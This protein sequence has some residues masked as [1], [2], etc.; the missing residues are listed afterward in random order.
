MKSIVVLAL[1]AILGFTAAGCGATKKIVV[2]VQTNTLKAEPNDYVPTINVRVLG[3]TAA[4]AHLKAGTRIECRYLPGIHVTAPAT[5]A[6]VIARSGA[7]ELRLRR[8]ANGSIR[9]SCPVH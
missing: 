3:S 9:V 8:L 2:D 7:K 1:I 4:I 5:R 6:A